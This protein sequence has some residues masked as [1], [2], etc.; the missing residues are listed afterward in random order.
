M[1]ASRAPATRCAHCGA[2]IDDPADGG[3]VLIHHTRADGVAVRLDGIYHRQCAAAAQA[4]HTAAVAVEEI[5]SAQARAATDAVAAARE[6][7]TRRAILLNSC[8]RMM[9]GFGVQFNAIALIGGGTQDVALVDLDAMTTA[10]TEVMRGAMLEGIERAAQEI[11]TVPGRPG[12]RSEVGEML[13]I[14][15]RAAGARL[16]QGMRT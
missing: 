4:R 3:G 12:V 10:M 15:I 8:R 1:T 14:R 6:H 11:E 2:A 16:A 13:A 5:E 7:A 9:A